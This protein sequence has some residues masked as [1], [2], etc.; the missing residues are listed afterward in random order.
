VLEQA[1]DGDPQL[2]PGFV[3]AFGD[4][5]AN[6]KDQVPPISRQLMHVPIEITPL[7]AFV[8]A[9]GNLVQSVAS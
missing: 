4:L 9:R 6:A 7:G 5:A 3:G 8:H 2:C 1:V